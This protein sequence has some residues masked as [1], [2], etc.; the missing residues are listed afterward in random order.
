MTNSISRRSFLKHSGALGSVVGA[1]LPVALNLTMPSQ[2]MAAPGDDTSGYRALVCVFLAGG[3]DAFNTIVRTDSAAGLQRYRAARSNV[4][5]PDDRLT[6]LNITPANNH[7]VPATP[8][9]ALKINDKLPNLCSMFNEGKLA[10][11]GNIGPLVQNMTAAEYVPGSSTV[12]AKLFSHND[13]QSVWQSGQP[14]GAI[15]GWGGELVRRLSAQNR[16][17]TLGTDDQQLFAS[18]AVESSPVFCNGTNTKM[19]GGKPTI[20]MFGA[21]S[22][23]GALRP[24]GADIYSME[25]TG[26]SNSD[27]SF[28]GMTRL[29]RNATLNPIFEGSAGMSTLTSTVSTKHFIES[30]Y[31]KKLK[32]A[33]DAWLSMFTATSNITSSTPPPAGNRLANQLRVVA[34][35][36]KARSATPL[37]MSRQVFFVQLGGFDTHSGQQLGGSEHDR[38]MTQ[39]ND[40]LFYFDTQLGADRSL[41]TTFTASEFGRKLHANGDGTDHGWGGHHFVMGGALMGKDSQNK[42]IWLRGGVYGN[43]PDLSTWNGNAYTDTQLLSDGT[44][45]PKVSVDVFAKEMGQWL[46]IDW[47][48]AENKLVA[49]QLFP[50]LSKLA[51]LPGIIT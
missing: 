18:V 41:V 42:D 22:R 25:T 37:S 6:A 26:P 3:N 13:Q 24:G 34:D 4:A 7:C 9:L 23:G 46:G 8:S 27:Y 17:T 47:S 29:G 5:L 31:C 16:V 33:N 50:N 44:L 20:T 40:A 45:V 49:E 2:A 19:P 11:I 10:I 51:P 48:T 14:E 15:S 30:D 21:A 38:L 12:P 28:W 1:G 39:L 36:I 43:F 32:S 35:I